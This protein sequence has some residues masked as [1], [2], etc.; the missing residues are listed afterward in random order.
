MFKTI[1][2]G[3]IGNDAE[4]TSFDNG[5]KVVTFSVAHSKKWTDKNGVKQEKTTWIRCNMWKQENLAQYLK[6][7]TRVMVE[8]EIEARAYTNKEQQNVASLELTVFAIEMQS[9]AE[10]SN[11]AVNTQGAVNNTQGAV[12]NSTAVSTPPQNLSTPPVS[13]T[14]GNNTV[15]NTKFTPANEEENDLPF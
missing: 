14:T 15:S 10:K 1:L 3:N 8:G 5:S 9:F 4:V 7:G 6:K 11:D 2:T 12:N 13:P